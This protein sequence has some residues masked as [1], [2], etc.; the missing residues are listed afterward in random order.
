MLKDIKL[1]YPAGLKRVWLFATAEP[2][3]TASVLKGNG[4]RFYD[5]TGV[6]R[7]KLGVW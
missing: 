6:L 4:L 7:V 5:G 1:Y 3:Q 2:A